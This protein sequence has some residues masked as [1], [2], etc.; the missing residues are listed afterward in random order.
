[1]AFNLIFLG[2]LLAV[3]GA[4]A[5]LHPALSR[6]WSFSIV[7]QAL[8]VLAAIGMGWLYAE[9]EGFGFVVGDPPY[10]TGEAKFDFEAIWI[11]A[12][13]YILAAFYIA[14]ISIWIVTRTVNEMRGH[15]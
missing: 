5:F 12:A 14:R 8:S 7:G 13:T 3:V 2:I 15:A 11:S 1:M 4:F 10:G 9:V 6:S